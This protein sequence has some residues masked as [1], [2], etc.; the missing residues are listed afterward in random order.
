M[1]LRKW[2]NQHTFGLIVGIFST[3][4]FIPIVIFI[5]S[6]FEEQNFYVLWDRFKF[7]RDHTSKFISL[8]CI[9]NLIWFHLS[10]RKQKYNFAMGV[11]L[12]TFIYFCIIIYLKYFSY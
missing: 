11:I 3:L 4:I 2:T 10:I 8:A 7:L 1:N 9:S 12:A 5:Y 6:F